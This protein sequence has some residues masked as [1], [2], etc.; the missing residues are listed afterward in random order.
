ML[1]VKGSLGAGP[2]NH[3]AGENG[4]LANFI[5][6]PPPLPQQNSVTSKQHI[7]RTGDRT[8]GKTILELV[9]AAQILGT[10]AV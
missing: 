10:F 9:L 6:F 1:Q 5:H 2:Y 4:W 8:P 7:Q 3:F